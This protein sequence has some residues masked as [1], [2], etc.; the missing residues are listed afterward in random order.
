MLGSK[1]FAE[2]AEALPD[3]LRAWLSCISGATGMTENGLKSN[4]FPFVCY[5]FP[6]PVLGIVNRYTLSSH[7]LS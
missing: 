5:A 6:S 7:L 1:E 3:Y 4:V 2:S